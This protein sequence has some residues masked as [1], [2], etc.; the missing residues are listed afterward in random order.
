MLVSNNG[1]SFK[2]LYYNNI[3]NNKEISELE[4][5]YKI[6]QSNP[7]FEFCLDQIEDIFG[8]TNISSRL[9][10]K[11]E[12]NNLIKFIGPKENKNGV[13]VMHYKIIDPSRKFNIKKEVRLDSKILDIEKKIHEILRFCINPKIK[14]G[15]KKKILNMLNNIIIELGNGELI[16]NISIPDLFY[17]GKTG[18]VKRIEGTK[19]L[20]QIIRFVNNYKN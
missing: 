15:N 11:L 16:E 8:K 19:F 1:N 14:Y 5:L 20:D 4:Y 18:E 7:K 9:F 12:V 3:E 2:D 6:M 17:F 13:K 10:R